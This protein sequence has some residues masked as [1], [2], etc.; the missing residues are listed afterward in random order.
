MLPS[1]SLLSIRIKLPSPSDDGKVVG[2]TSRVPGDENARRRVG[3]LSRWVD[4]LVF[5]GAIQDPVGE[6]VEKA[7]LPKSLQ[8]NIGFIREESDCIIPAK[9]LM[10]FWPGIGRAH[11]YNNALRVHDIHVKALIS[12]LS[13]RLLGLPT[14]VYQ[15]R[16]S[17]LPAKHPVQ[18]R[19]QL[20][21]CSFTPKLQTPR[22]RMITKP[23]LGRVLGRTH[24]P[25]DDDEHVDRATYDIRYEY[26]MINPFLMVPSP[27]VF[28]SASVNADIQH[29]RP[30]SR[31]IS[32]KTTDFL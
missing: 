18:G 14:I 16:Q 12:F 30:S 8:R 29:T 32:R 17:S 4:E 24:G 22:N 15:N 10:Y 28:L 19:L 25:F 26:D 27:E 6:I 2:S 5:K 20:S 7:T 3:K 11:N 31:D 21:P 13:Q 9:I 23:A 1:G